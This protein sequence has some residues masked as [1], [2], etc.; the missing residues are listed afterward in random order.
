M[1][2]VPIPDE[3]V[4]GHLRRHVV[5]APDGDLT[6]DRVRAV[7]VL[8]GVDPELGICQT[9]LV[10]LDPGDIDRLNRMAVPAVWL[11]MYTPQ[12]PVFNLEVADGAG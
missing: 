6:N 3:L 11:S 2:P 1:R 9:M 5:A 8:A 10:A 4:Q 7:E 12:L